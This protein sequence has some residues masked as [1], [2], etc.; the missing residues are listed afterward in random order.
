MYA[1]SIL[2]SNL[3]LTVLPFS[4]GWVDDAEQL[5]VGD[6][7]GVQIVQY[8]LPLHVGVRLVQHLQNLQNNQV[9]QC[10]TDRSAE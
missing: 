8:W 6:S 10:Y 1:K 2:L 9:N 5:I 4:G 7:L 3:E